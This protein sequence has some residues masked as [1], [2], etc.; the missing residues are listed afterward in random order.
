MKD[1]VIIMDDIC[2]TCAFEDACPSAHFHPTGRIN[3][4]GDYKSIKKGVLTDGIYQTRKSN[5]ATL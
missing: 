1:E 2:N 5:G 3:V 4:C